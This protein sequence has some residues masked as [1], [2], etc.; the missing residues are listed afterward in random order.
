[1]CLYAL[2][3]HNQT[4][5]SSITVLEWMDA[6]KLHMKIQNIGKFYWF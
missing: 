2:P 3:K 1:M 4:P 6:F 5:H